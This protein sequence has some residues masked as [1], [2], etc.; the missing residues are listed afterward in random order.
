M[1]WLFS[2]QRGCRGGR[3]DGGRGD[4]GR[5][6][7]GRGGRGGRGGS[8]SSSGGRRCVNCNFGDD[9][10]EFMGHGAAVRQFPLWC[11]HCGYL[12]VDVGRSQR[13]QPVMEN[14]Q[15]VLRPATNSLTAPA[16]GQ[17]LV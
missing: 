6:D 10:L 14:G 7:R 4:R 5:G 12:R 2:G 3:G 17:A 16:P 11:P 1:L 15:L 9:E 8:S 13:F